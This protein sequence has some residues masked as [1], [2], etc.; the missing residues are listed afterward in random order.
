M[1]KPLH[2]HYGRCQH[3]IHKCDDFFHVGRF[4][5]LFARFYAFLSFSIISISPATVKDV[6]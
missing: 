5:V 3:L 2:D 6:I 1:N 4:F